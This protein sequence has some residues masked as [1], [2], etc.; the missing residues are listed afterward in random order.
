MRTAP[1]N[2]RRIRVAVL[3]ATGSVGQRFLSL[4]ADHPWFE[5]GALT[6]SERS[7]DRS[8][9]EATP[10]VQ[11]VPLRPEVAAMQ[12]HR[13]EPSAV[14][15]CPLVF[16]ALDARVAGE[17][18]RAF[19]D[20]GRLVVSNARNHRLK[21]SV[22]V[23]VPEVNPDHLRLVDVQRRDGGTGAI[24]TNPNCSTIGLVLALKPLHDAFGVRTVNVVT[25]QA[26]SGAGLPGIPSL[27]ILD[28]V[29][30]YIPGE[31]EKIEAETRKILGR[32]EDGR[33]AECTLA[34][35]AQCNRVPVVD[36]H[37]MCVSVGLERAADPAEVRRA[38]ETF[39]GGPAAG[40]LPSAPERPIHYL[41]APDAPQARLHR[42]VDRGMAAMVGRLRPCPL[43]SFR[44]VVLSHNTLRGAAGGALLLAELAAA[45]GLVPGFAPVE[46]AS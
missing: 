43:A 35:S 10:W 38:F 28:N 26:V 13:T 19:A 25:L 30:P 29:I 34:I 44:F 32:F 18:E 11:T 36:G 27:Q 2:G 9:G 16:S 37:T 8:Y 40:E 1:W 24:V 45:R 42:D 15:E 17:V 46:V 12:V 6:A 20:A 41:D 21:P 31:E 23:V 5:L 33:I 14:P 4:L 7:A 22:P 39:S 3:G